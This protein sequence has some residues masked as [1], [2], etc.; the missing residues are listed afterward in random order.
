MGICFSCTATKVSGCT[1]N[2]RTGEL[3][4][5]PDKPIQICIN[6]PVGDVDIAL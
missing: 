5:D 6:A 4:A 3:D 1:R 2:V